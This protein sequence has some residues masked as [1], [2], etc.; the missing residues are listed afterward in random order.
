VSG[1]RHAGR[2]A[3]Q[4]A[5]TR[6]TAVPRFIG[7]KQN[8]KILISS[9]KDYLGA[10]N[11][12]PD[13]RKGKYKRRSIKEQVQAFRTSLYRRETGMINMTPKENET[14]FQLYLRQIAQ[15]PLLTPEQEIK[16]A[17]QI[18]QGNQRARTEMVSA[19]LRLVVKIARDY[20]NFGL[21]LLDLVSE[22]NIG[23]MKAVERFDPKKGGKLSTYAAWWIRQSIKRALANQTKTIRLPVH[24]VEKISRMRRV[25]SRMMEEL[26]REPSDDELAEEIGL[27][28][29]KI[30]ALKSAALRP[31]SLDE[32][33]QD[34]E[35]FQFGDIV[36][37]EESENPF[38]TLRDKDT[39]EEIDEVLE[40]LEYRERIIINLRFGLD[41][42]EPKTLEEIG[43]NIG[44][45]RERIRQLQ[46]LALA[47]LR[48]ALHRRERSRADTNL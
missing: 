24:L 33:V 6:E 26:G 37:D 22:G 34:G 36:S 9:W 39:L 16:L 10:R 27:S 32:P 19:N 1:L 23:L 31:A 20:V 2:A 7:S 40:V 43:K 30:T 17:R 21:P 38:E 14:A 44:V 35:G 29:S 45:T 11:R 47:K 46:N 41:G 15:I 4:V 12:Q 3:R 18:K 13:R 25:S 8:L 28:V 48:A 42:Q 5:S